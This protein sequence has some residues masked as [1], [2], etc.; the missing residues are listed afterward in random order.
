MVELF[1]AGASLFYSDFAI[2]QQA[3]KLGVPEEGRRIRRVVRKASVRSNK[4]WIF[5]DDIH[6][7][8]A[9][10]PICKAVL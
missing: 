10:V 5:T 7:T 3:R 2:G 6:S 1:V 9:Q 4:R 8:S